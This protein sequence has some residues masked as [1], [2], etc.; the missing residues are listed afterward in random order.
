MATANAI[1]DVDEEEPFALPVELSA[2]LAEGK[3]CLSRWVDVPR[4]SGRGTFRAFH[5][6][7]ETKGKGAAKRSTEIP[8][9]PV[10][11]EFDEAKVMELKGLYDIVARSR[12]LIGC[13]A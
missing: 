3:V 13:Q 7:F 1:V 11:P 2:L 5:T 9:R 12:W 6:C 4:T 10:G 8:A